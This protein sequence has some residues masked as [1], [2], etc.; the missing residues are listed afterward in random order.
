MQNT[1]THNTTIL[2]RLNSWDGL[3]CACVY[4]IYAFSAQ[5]GKDPRAKIPSDV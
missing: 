3:V 1:L 5:E 4:S 2:N